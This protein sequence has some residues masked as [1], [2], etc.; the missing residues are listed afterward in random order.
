MLCVQGSPLYQWDQH[1]QL[2]ID[3]ID[4]STN[5]KVHCCHKD[6]TETLVV[7]PIIQEDSV[8][9]NIPN[10][11][12]QE[13][14][15]IQ[16]YVVV[17]EDTI[18]D[19]S[20]Y[21]LA[22]P[23]PG[24][25]VYEETELFTIETA[26]NRALQ[27]AKDNGDFKGEPGESGYTPQKDKDYFDGKD[28]KTPYIKDGYWWI[29]DT[30]TEVKAEGTDGEPGKDGESVFIATYGQTTYSDMK[31]AWKAGKLVVLKGDVESA[32]TIRMLVHISTDKIFFGRVLAESGLIEE[33]IVTSGNKWTLIKN[34]Y[35]NTDSLA[36]QLSSYATTSYVSK[37]YAKKS[38]IPTVPDVSGYATQSWVNNK[39]YATQSWVKDEGMTYAP[40]TLT[41]VFQPKV[42][43]KLICE[44]NKTYII[45]C[46]GS[47]A[48]TVRGYGDQNT[49]SSGNPQEI[50]GKYLTV[51]CGGQYDTF[52]DGNGNTLSNNGAA[53]WYAT[54]MTQGT[55]TPI[56]SME[57]RRGVVHHPDGD[58]FAVI[59]Y[60]SSCTIVIN[61][62][63]NKNTT[64]T[65]TKNYFM[66]GDT[67]YFFDSST[68]TWDKWLNSRY[69][70]DD[71]HETSSYSTMNYTIVAMSGTKMIPD[72][73][74]DAG[75]TYVDAVYDNTDG[76]LVGANDGSKIVGGRTYS[77]GMAIV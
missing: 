48:A 6:D 69:N 52:D 35:V 2:K 58:Q 11:L 54:A 28:G 21:V 19:T 60:P 29:G 26:V 64:E 39:N 1:R 76:R 16:V 75:N 71:F 32:L 43:G 74:P 22:R 46:T 53:L 59:S 17:G 65:K 25:Y 57:V 66:I 3:S 23:K 50:S 61:E 9:V 27:Q 34:T 30:N 8:L 18:Y 14:G 44:T 45:Y 38:D 67:A 13:S 33:V 70:T 7:E 12:L 73:E 5:F 42:S 47:V 10:I 31:N 77:V 41:K 20:F 37:N 55:I 36:S 72:G 24:D 40:K 63:A 62:T 56:G 51:Y 68:D 49:D 4:L 15:I